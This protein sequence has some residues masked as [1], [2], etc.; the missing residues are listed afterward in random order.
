[1]PQAARKDW[2]Q[3]LAAALSQVLRFNDEKAWIQLLSLPQMVLR[4]Q[5]RGGTKNKKRAAADV[6]SRCRSWLEGQRAKLWQPSRRSKPQG[7]TELTALQREERATAWVKEDLYQK[8]CS[9]LSQ[10]PPVKVTAAVVAQMKDKHPPARDSE[11]DRTAALRRVDGRAAPTTSADEVEKGV[12]SFPR[13][14]AAGLTALRPQHLKDALVPGHKD[15]VLRQLT[16][17]VELLARGEAAPVVR[18]WICGGSLT[19]LAKPD[20]GLR[21]VAVGE[22]LRRLVGK[23]LASVVSEDI[24]S[25]LEP[26]QVGVGTKGGCEAVVHVVRQWLGRSRSDKDRVLVMMDLSN[27]FN[28]LDRSAFRQAVRRVVPCIAPWVDFCYGDAS[29]LLLGDHPLESARGIQQGDPLGPALFSL[30][31]QGQ[32]HKAR[33]ETL[34]EYPGELDFTVFYLDDGVLGGSSRAVG[35]FCER[36]GRYFLDVGLTMHRGKCEIVPAAGPEHQVPV[37][38]F[39]GFNFRTEGNFK[40]LGAP[41]GTQEFCEA[42]T[43]RRKDKAEK[44]LRSIAAMQDTQCALHLVRHCASFCKLAYSARTV[45]PALHYA[46]LQEFS[47][48]VKAALAELVTSELDSLSWEQAKLGVKS[49]G[50]GLRSVDEHASAAYLAS[51]GAAQSI[52]RSIDASFDVTDGEGHLRLQETRQDFR[53]RVRTDAVVDVEEHVYRQKYLSQLI[54]AKVKEDLQDATRHD[55]YYQAHLALEGMHGAGAWLTAPPVDA[56]RTVDEALFR[57]CLQ[58]RLRVRVQDTDS[59]CPLCGHTMDSYGDHALVCACHGDRTVRHNALRNVVYTEALQGGLSPEKEK[60]G[61]LPG[62][63]HEDGVQCQGGA[64]AEGDEQSAEQTPTRGRRRPADVYLPRGPGGRAAALDFACTSGLRADRARAATENPEE[65]VANYEAFKRSFKPAGDLETTEEQ[66]TRQGFGFIPMVL[67]SHSGGWG[68][69]ARQTLDAIAKGVS[70]SAGDSAEVA[71]LRI[72][73][74][75][76]VTLQRENARAILR[77]LRQPEQAEM[78]DE[79]AVNEMPRW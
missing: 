9:A 24:K 8:A 12:R 51:V 15:E 29:P 73:Q 47:G 4:A 23:V 6:R 33:A 66:C 41:F 79:L 1:V 45:P 36:L 61:L 13:G 14:S 11:E 28:C 5:E 49:G 52:C 42:H 27:A 35:D 34:R 64:E 68:K 54:D 75:L 59:F 77:R 20:G 50:L 22:T 25:Y 44:L 31:V 57:I 37:D 30:A 76:S 26:L 71:C 46:A 7:T 3:C 72:A 19:A 78:A 70:A 74:R 32:I 18:K 10:E 48:T 62:R 63:P 58:R 16:G 56:D 53:R 60:V 2:A 55:Q 38:T 67:E 40:L 69:T 21:P 39:Q 43:R 17:V 65:V